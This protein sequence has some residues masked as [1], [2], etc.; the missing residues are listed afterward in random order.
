MAG[1]VNAIFNK[2]AA[3]ERKEGYNKDDDNQIKF[4]EDEK[5]RLAG[6]SIKAQRIGLDILE[7]IKSGDEVFYWWKK[8]NRDLIRAGFEPDH[9]ESFDKLM[10]TA[11]K[12]LRENSYM[13]SPKKSPNKMMVWD[14]EADDYIEVTSATGSKTVEVTG[15]QATIPEMYAQNFMN[16]GGNG[17]VNV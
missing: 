15:S 14:D 17:P 1:E 6:I 7:Y 13:P 2:I 5:R 3:I 10:E 9:E 11:M 16:A 8:A 4:L 12:L